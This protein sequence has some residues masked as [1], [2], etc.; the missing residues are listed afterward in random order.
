MALTN[1]SPPPPSK[2]TG[3]NYTQW[4]VM[5]KAYL[6]AFDLWEVT[7]KGFESFSLPTNPTVAQSKHHSEQ[8]FNQYKA[9]TCIH[10]SVIETI[11]NRIMACD[12][13]KEAWD[14]L[15]EDFGGSSKTKTMQLLNL[16]REFEFLRMKDTETVKDYSDKL[17][18]VVN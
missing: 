11:F 7:E 18:K 2:F 9:L 3:E 15:K 1:F 6:R 16:R 12:T 10:S 4:T 14:R 8:V 17:L 13:A 5:M